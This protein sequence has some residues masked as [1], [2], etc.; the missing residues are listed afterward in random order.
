MAKK[1]M[2]VPNGIQVMTNSKFFYLLHYNKGPEFEPFI[3]FHKY[4]MEY[5]ID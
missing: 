1:A 3:D 5:T 2:M 4:W